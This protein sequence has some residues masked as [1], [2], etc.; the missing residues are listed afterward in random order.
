VKSH[1]LLDLAVWEAVQDEARKQSLPT[2][3]HVTNQVGLA[4]AGKAGQQ[5]EHL[6][7]AFFELLPPGSA[8]RSAEFGQLPPPQVIR[9]AARASDAALHALARLMAASRSYQVPTAA[10]FEKIVALDTSNEQLRAA[11]E[12]RFIPEASLNQWS[13][14]RDGLKQAGFTASDGEIFSGIR[15]R[16]I[17]AYHNAGVPIM[18]GS[19]TAQA[20][21]IWGPGLIQEIETLGKSG[22]SPMEALRSATV[23]P[24][25]YFR[26]LPNGGSSLG[27][28]AEFGTVEKGARADLILLERDPAKDL[29]ALRSL[30]MVIAGG[31]LYDRAALDAMLAKAAADAKQ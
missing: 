1:H 2:A 29:S 26:S 28:K 25:D 16:I 20:F 6:D 30:Q 31:R 8:E 10:L 17:R 9:A 23:V 11:T 7:G 3:G 12:M 4:R 15:R 24:R 27:W 21:H 5:V 14:Q 18:A 19:D 22:L 13:A